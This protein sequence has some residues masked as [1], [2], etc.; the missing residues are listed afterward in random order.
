M[1]KEIAK[2]GAHSLARI[3]SVSVFFISALFAIP[4]SIFNFY[5]GEMA[6]GAM[7]LVAPL[8]YALVSYVAEWI[9]AW[10]YNFFAS[11]VGGVEIELVDKDS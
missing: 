8:L 10:L 2:I 3:V 1:K 11:R 6:T 7:L 4:A 9:W 5:I